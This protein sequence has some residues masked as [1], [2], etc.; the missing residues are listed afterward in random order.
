MRRPSPTLITVT[1]FNDKCHL[2][3]GIDLW[4]RVRVRARVRVRLTVRARVVGR[5]RVRVKV[6]VKA[7]VSATHHSDLNTN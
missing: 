1:A 7:R 5:D 3:K 6:W 4:V 2:D